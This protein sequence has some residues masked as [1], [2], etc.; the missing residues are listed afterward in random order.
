MGLIVG[1][2]L[3]FVISVYF[4]EVSEDN[5][6][7]NC[8]TWFDGCNICNVVDGVIESCTKK[9]CLEYGEPRCLEFLK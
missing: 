2:V 3:G 4:V 5:S 1:F 8:V 6:L 7:D 9:D